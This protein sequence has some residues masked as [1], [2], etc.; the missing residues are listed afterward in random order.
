MRLPNLAL[1]TRERNFTKLKIILTPGRFK[2]QSSKFKVKT[3]NLS[4]NLEP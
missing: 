2:V 4:F 1:A 3:W